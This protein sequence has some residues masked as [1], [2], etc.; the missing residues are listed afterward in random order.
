M[1]ELIEK[2]EFLAT[3][4]AL[5]ARDA[6]GAAKIEEEEKWIETAFFC[7]GKET[8]FN[9]AFIKLDKI[10]TEVKKRIKE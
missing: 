10:I 4:F 3:Y 9:I 7:K 1:K 2:L 6:N 5:A 8:A